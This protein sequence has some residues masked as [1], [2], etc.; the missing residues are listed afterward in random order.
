[1]MESLIVFVAP[2]ENRLQEA[3]RGVGLTPVITPMHVG[4]LMICRRVGDG[5][6]AGAG[7]GAG[8]AA[9][10][11]AVL[12]NVVHWKPEGAVAE[13]SCLKP[14]V[15]I[16]RKTVD[17]FCSSLRSGHKKNQHLRLLQWRDNVGGVQIWYVIEGYEQL[18]GVVD[19]YGGVSMTVLEAAFLRLVLLDQIVVRQVY[20]IE[21]HA[22][23]VRKIC[24]LAVAEE[25][26]GG[27]LARDRVQEYAATLAIQK[28]ANLTPEMLYQQQV[29]CFPGVSMTTAAAIAARFGSWRLLL[30][31]LQ[32]APDPVECLSEISVGQRRLGPA[33]AQQ[34]CQAL[35][36]AIG[37]RGRKT[38]GRAKRAA[39]GGIERAVLT[40]A[41]PVVRIQ[42]REL[43]TK[44]DSI[45]NPP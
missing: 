27:V 15:I 3:L 19:H 10:H 14:L 9:C 20:N 23:V 21:E 45:Q 30:E 24:D 4:D 16:E 18:R 38:T 13:G 40:G 43:L 31:G 28:R 34:I 39:P 8:G 36:L 44:N 12:E 35:G 7:A 22:T 1:M 42:K 2:G 37:E 25:W 33:R 5:D 6:G 17:D 11:R 41:R 29:A 32:T 26:S